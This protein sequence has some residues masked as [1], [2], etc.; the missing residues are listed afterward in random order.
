MVHD[1]I[2]N[3]NNI[4]ESMLEGFDQIYYNIE[5]STPVY[6]QS[7]SNF[8]QEFLTTWKNLVHS[9]LSTQQ[10]YFNKI[11]LT[12][13]STEIISQIIQ[14]MTDE[15]GMNFKLQNSIIKTWL[16]TSEQNIHAINDN[17]TSFSNVNKKFIES[18]SNMW[19][20]P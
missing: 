15:M 5:Q 9:N 7:I 11:G 4:F 3:K 6:T 8:Q 10:E 14:K 1:K 18:L 16:D 19:N 13:E 17:S 20:V 12:S 2:Q